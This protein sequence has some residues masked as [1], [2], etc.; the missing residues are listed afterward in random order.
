ME[1][2]TAS[3]NSNLEYRQAESHQSEPSLRSA[4]QH[5]ECHFSGTYLLSWTKVC[6]AAK[7]G[8]RISYCL[9]SAPFYMLSIVL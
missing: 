3:R 5:L 8:Q 1:S 9:A 2:L 4:E 7:T 6:A